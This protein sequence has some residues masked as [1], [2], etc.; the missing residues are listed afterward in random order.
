MRDKKLNEGIVIRNQFYLP[1]FWGVEFF[2][3]PESLESV[4]LAEF[5]SAELI[6]V[7]LAFPPIVLPVEV[8]WG[9]REQ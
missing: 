9:L 5:L 4:V 1:E 7:P 3:T 6:D 8:S 2:P